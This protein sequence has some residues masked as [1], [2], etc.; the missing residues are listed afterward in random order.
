MKKKMDSAHLYMSRNKYRVTWLHDG[1]CRPS[2]HIWAQHKSPGYEW[3]A[4]THHHAA[5]SHM[6]LVP[7]HVYTDEQSAIFF[8]LS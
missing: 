2:I 3:R 7:R 6:I 5:M 8:I 4:C 1:G